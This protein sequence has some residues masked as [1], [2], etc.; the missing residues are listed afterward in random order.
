MTLNRNFSKIFFHN[1]QIHSLT[2][3]LSQQTWTIYYPVSE[4]V[5]QII[6][7]EDKKEENERAMQSL[8]ISDLQSVKEHVPPVECFLGRCVLSSL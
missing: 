3:F 5:K 7:R 8:V 4:A 2:Q 6:G 1:F